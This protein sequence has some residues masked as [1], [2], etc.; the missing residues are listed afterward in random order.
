MLKC[1]TYLVYPVKSCKSFKSCFIAGRATVGPLLNR[2]ISTDTISSPVPTGFRSVYKCIRQKYMKMT[3]SPAATARPVHHPQRQK[4]IIRKNCRK[5][6]ECSTNLGAGQAI[7]VED[8]HGSRAALESLYEACTGA[9]QEENERAV[10]AMLGSLP[11]F[12]SQLKSNIERTMAAMDD[13]KAPLAENER[14]GRKG[15]LQALLAL[16]TELHQRLQQRVDET[17]Q[18]RKAWEEDH[19]IQAAQ[20]HELSL[21]A[22]SLLPLLDAPSARTISTTRWQEAEDS[23]ASL[24]VY[25]LDNKISAEQV[26]S[27]GKKGIDP[28]LRDVLRKLEEWDA[29]GLGF[30]KDE[31]VDLEVVEKIWGRVDKIASGLNY[32]LILDARGDMVEGVVSFARHRP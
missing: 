28:V 18:T 9:D 17:L 1:L 26:R 22:Q 29:E 32:L 2:I 23:L 25:L 19:P 7:P 8:V 12:L 15:A 13:D 31:R 14:E 16:S 30:K 4:L 5:I 24:Q 11:C 3:S 27:S 21:Y 20:E 10:E 6:K